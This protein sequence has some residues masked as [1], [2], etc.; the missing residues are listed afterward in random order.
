MVSLLVTSFATTL[1]SLTLQIPAVRRALDI[2]IVPREYRG[3]LPSL[4]DTASYVVKSWKAKVAEA[5]TQTRQKTAP[6]RK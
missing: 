2:P 4:M 5:Q 1:Q 3:K 6:R